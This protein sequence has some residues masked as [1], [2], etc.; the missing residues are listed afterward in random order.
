MELA[1]QMSDPFGED[2]TDFPVLGWLSEVLG[3]AVSLVERE[4]EFCAD[5]WQVKLEKETSLGQGTGCFNIAQH[6]GENAPEHVEGFSLGQSQTCSIREC[7]FEPHREAK[8]SSAASKTIPLQP[9]V[10][11]VS[12]QTIP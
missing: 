12:D 8:L 10:S 1:S 6:L 5:S 7:C 3:I 2:A 11:D 9:V 4:P